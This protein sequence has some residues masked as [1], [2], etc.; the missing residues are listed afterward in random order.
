MILCI[1][2]KLEVNV[3][4]FKVILIIIAVL[5]VLGLLFFWFYK[6]KLVPKMDEYNSLMQANKVTVSI[7]VID[8]MKD[9]LANQNMPKVVLEQTPKMLRNK[10]LPL[11]KAKIGPQIQ[12]LITDEKV[13]KNIPV[14][15]MVKVDLAGMYIINIK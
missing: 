3:D 11:V 7:F 10:K 5:A 13:F 15:K 8:K 6:K 9:K 4:I 2:Y 1:K 14:K 12:T